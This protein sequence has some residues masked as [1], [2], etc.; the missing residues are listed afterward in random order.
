MVLQWYHFKLCLWNEVTQS[1]SLPTSKATPIYE[2]YKI[3][4]H[5][6]QKLHKVTAILSAPK[7]IP[8]TKNDIWYINA[9]QVYLKKVTKTC[10]K[11]CYCLKVTSA[12]KW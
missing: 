1:L 4:C 9:V 3:I 2:G 12:K 10:L 11:S 7:P 8:T 5:W 6:E